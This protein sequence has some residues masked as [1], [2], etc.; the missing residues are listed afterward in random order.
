MK[1]LTACNR[2]R[3]INKLLEMN[4]HGP[5]KENGREFMLY[6]GQRMVIPRGQQFTISQFRFL[7]NEVEAIVSQDEWQF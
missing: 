6:H 1:S 3:F 4:C 7:I 2:E 5:I